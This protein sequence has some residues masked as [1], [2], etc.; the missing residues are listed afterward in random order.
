MLHADLTV[1]EVQP[2]LGLRCHSG[3]EAPSMFR[4]LGT[5][6]PEEPTKFFQVTS[7]NN[8]QVNGVYCEPCLIVANA[9]SR[10]EKEKM[11]IKIK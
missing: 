11:E 5:K 1:K 8:P 7:S 3:H 9:M 4:R 2:P 6:A 10:Q